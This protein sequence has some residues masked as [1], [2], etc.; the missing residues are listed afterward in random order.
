MCSEYARLRALL[1]AS[2]DYA[3][4]FRTEVLGDF[5]KIVLVYLGR[6]SAEQAKPQYNRG[7]QIFRQFMGILEKKYLT[8]RRPADYAEELFLSTSRSGWATFCRVVMCGHRL[9]C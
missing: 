9:K 5:L 7:T 2:I 4:L 1:E 6:L 3:G 8:H